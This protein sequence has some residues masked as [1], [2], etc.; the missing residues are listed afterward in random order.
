MWSLG[1]C[2]YELLSSS[3]ETKEALAKNIN[4]QHR[5]V[6][7]CGHS[8]FPLSPHPEYK[9]DDY[10]QFDQNDLLYHNVHKIRDITDDDLSF[11]D[12]EDC[13]S[14]VRKIS[15][16]KPETKLDFDNLKQ[17][18]ESDKIHDGFKDILKN[19]LEFNPYFRWSPQE[20]LGHPMFDKMRNIYLEQSAK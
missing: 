5:H 7:F 8:C 17:I 11:I 9:E 6:L 4:S 12:V 20:C 2:L 1:C 14:Y 19:L 13:K 15:N 3:I 18:Y 16:R 10:F